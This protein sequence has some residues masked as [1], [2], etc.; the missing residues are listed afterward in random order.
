MTAVQSNS[1][2]PKRTSLF[3]ETFTAS[4]LMATALPPLRWIV[5]GLLP[6]GITLLAGKPKLG[7]W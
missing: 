3:A 4:E 7:P 2:A 1:E 5:P 6:E